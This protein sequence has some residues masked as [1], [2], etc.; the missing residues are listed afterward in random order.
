MS[1]GELVLSREQRDEIIKAVNAIQRQLKEMAH[2]ARPLALYVISNNLA[3]IQTNVANL[4]RVG[5]N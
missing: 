2:G 5:R 1:D 4:P 3:V